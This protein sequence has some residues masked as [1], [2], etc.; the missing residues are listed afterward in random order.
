MEQETKKAEILSEV[1]KENW[2]GKA[3]KIKTSEE[4]NKEAKKEA[5]K[6]SK[7]RLRKRLRKSLYGERQ[8]SVRES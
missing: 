7:K 4:T 3:A 1:R 6:E 8:I 2:G 5:K